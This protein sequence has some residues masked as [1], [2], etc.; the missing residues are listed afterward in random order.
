MRKEGFLAQ[1]R[2]TPADLSAWLVYADWFEDQDDQTGAF[3]RLSLDLTAGLIPA[4]DA[5]ARIA[6]F[7]QLLAGSDPETRELLAEY[8][9]SLPVRFRVLSRHFIG[10][11]PPREMFGYARTVLVGFLEAGQVKP[12]MNL[13]VGMDGEG[14]PRILQAIETFARLHEE[15]AAGREPIQAGLCWLGHLQTEVGAVLTEVSPQRSG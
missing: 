9:S 11:N 7:E 2:A 14:R 5:E 1:L 10:A 8:R 12:R 4:K 3:I 13:G 15:I 6:E